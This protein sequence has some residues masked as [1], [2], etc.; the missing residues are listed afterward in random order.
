MARIL[1]GLPSDHGRTILAIVWGSGSC[2]GT[3]RSSGTG[4]IMVRV[5]LLVG[6]RVL[7][8]IGFVF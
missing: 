8:G 5:R 2:F 1:G 4:Q 6:V 3:S 7:V